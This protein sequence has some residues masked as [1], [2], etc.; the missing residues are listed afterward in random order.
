[1]KE[2]ELTPVD[3]LSHDIN[4]PDFDPDR[5]I[6]SEEQA[7][8]EVVDGNVEPA[9]KKRSNQGD[10]GEIKNEVDRYFETLSKKPR[11][12]ASQEVAVAK[13]I[14]EGSEEARHRMAEA[15]LR[16]VVSIAKHYVGVSDNFQM[17]ELIQEGNIGL[18]KA[19]DKFDY[20]MGY[21]FSTYATYW[22]RREISRAIT[23]KS[24]MISMPSGK[25]EKIIKLHNVQRRI[26]ADSSCESQDTELAER[27]GISEEGVRN[28][29]GTNQY[30]VI[31]LNIKTDEEEESELIDFIK[32]KYM[33]PEEFTV[34]RHFGRQV[35]RLVSPELS[36]LERKIVY[37]HFG[38]GTDKE[39]SLK[40]VADVV[41][42]DYFRVKDIKTIAM[43][44]LRRN[45]HKFKNLL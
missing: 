12:S 8:N 33:S 35:I 43:S 21:K 25:V 10:A 19:I 37:M 23:D 4:F 15:N 34:A 16:L 41:G 45:R 28:I 42:L 36:D 2:Q 18:M 3:Y 7:E 13:E 29:K 17:M 44:R 26:A 39:Y 9:E 14:A 27:M 38:I 1:M 11:L 40:E 20:T 6:L 24:R 31:S 22:I 32:S 30:R 5:I